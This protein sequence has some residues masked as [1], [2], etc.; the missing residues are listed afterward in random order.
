MF[1]VTWF[2]NESENQK[3]WC[4]L[5]GWN[6][7]IQDKNKT[8]HPI[9][10]NSHPLATANKAIHCL[11]WGGA[12]KPTGTSY[13]LDKARSGACSISSF[14]FLRIHMWFLYFLGRLFRGIFLKDLAQYVKA[15]L[16]EEWKEPW[17]NTWTNQQIIGDY[18]AFL[19]SFEPTHKGYSFF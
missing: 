4:L 13:N 6:S 7:D 9:S 8:N 3:T 17:W 18:R 5:H 16:W 11:K 10:S 1:L 14:E 15:V 19:V 2:Y 12:T